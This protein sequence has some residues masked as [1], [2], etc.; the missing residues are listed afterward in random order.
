MDATQKTTDRMIIVTAG[1]RQWDYAREE[2]GD[3]VT[4][5]FYGQGEHFRGHKHIIGRVIVSPDGKS[6]FYRGMI[7]FS[8]SKSDEQARLAE[9]GYDPEL[10]NDPLLFPYGLPEEEEMLPAKVVLAHVRQWE[11]I[12]D[13]LRA[14]IERAQAQDT[15]GATI[16]K[17]GASVGRLQLKPPGRKSDEAYG[18]TLEERDA[19]LLVQQL[20]EQYNIPQLRQL[21]FEV[22]VD[23]E[24]IP[25]ET[26]T[27]LARELVLYCQ[28]QGRLPVLERKVREERPDL[29]W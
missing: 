8:I 6:D 14:E 18:A 16:G 7:S 23:H 10:V 22:G 13:A 20:R 12:R 3:V 29:D 1:G 24:D 15:A 9:R 19:G 21:A 27:D 4:F 2:E 26:K 11:I 5:T 25:S 28:R 17:E